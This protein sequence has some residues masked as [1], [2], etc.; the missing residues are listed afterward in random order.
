MP[1]LS[2]LDDLIHRWAASI[3]DAT[4]IRYLDTAW[5]WSQWNDRIGRLAGALHAAGITRG[6]RIACLDKNHPASLEITLAAARLGATAVVLNWRLAGDELDYAIQDAGVRWMFC[7]A[8][9]YPAVAASESRIGALPHVTKIGG[10]SDDYEA[11]VGSAE[12]LP[13]QRDVTPDDVCVIMYSSGT[14]GRPKGVMLTQRNLVAH[15]RNIAEQFELERGTHTNLVAMPLFHVGGTAY[16]LLGIYAGV[17]TIMTREPDPASLFAALAGGAT[18]AF[19]VPPVISAILA[20]GPQAVER[21]SQ[22]QT[23][24][25]GAAPTPL[26]LLQRALQ[27]WPQ[28]RFI[29]V[30]GQTEFAGAIAMLDPTDHR[31]PAHPER[32]LSTGKPVRGAEVR[33][34]DPNTGRDV[35]I[36]GSGEF[37][38]RTEQTMAGYLNRPD[39][40]AATIT[41]NGWLRTGDIGRIDDDGYLYVEDRVKDMIITGGEN[42]YSPEIERV[43]LSHP[44]IADAAVFGI[45]DDH[46]GET[47][48]AVIV[49]ADGENIS[50]ERVQ[51]FA[52]EQLAGYKIP[53]R[54]EFIDTIPRNASGKVLKREL[55]EPYWRDHNRRV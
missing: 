7:G 40:T 20:A 19:L 6:D 15:T 5:S 45:P 49:L 52:R 28:M 13:P 47:V 8:E 14:T 37:W 27:A 23:L 16:A 9:L 4:A 51:Q 42:V 10:G 12:P 31:D 48:I 36:N 38:L 29:Q 34:V 22:L 50:I 35:P 46:W 3:P 33:V 43:L 18:H 2:L 26:P 44:T 1:E 54:I 39:D 41:E 17:P 21:L 53:R 55:R 25:Y 30:Y 24:G 11:L 32:L